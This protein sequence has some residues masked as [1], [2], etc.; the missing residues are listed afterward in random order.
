MKLSFLF[1][2]LLVSLGL[3]VSA[4][5]ARLTG[6]VLDENKQ[7][8]IA[9]AVRILSDSTTIIKGTLVDFDGNYR[10]EVKPGVYT[11]VASLTGYKES[12]FHKIRLQ[13]GD[14]T[15]EFTM[16]ENTTTL[17]EV[18]MIASDRT[19]SRPTTGRNKDHKTAKKVVKEKSD[20]GKSRK[21]VADDAD[22]V[23]IKGSRSEGT[24]YYID[25][26][27]V[28]TTAPKPSAISEP[29]KP[30][31]PGAP[32][33]TS[34]D[35][36]GE[37]AAEMLTKISGVEVA[38]EHAEDLPEGGPK[39]P[40]APRAGLLTAGEWND[41]HNW[42]THWIDLLADG[43]ITQYQ[44]RYQF[45]PVHRYTIML[46]N[47]NDFPIVDVPVKLLG[48][49]LTVWEAR[50]DN[51]GKAELWSGMFQKGAAG[52]QL[53]LVAVINGKET[54]LGE[55]KPAKEGI[56]RYRMPAPCYTP[57]NVDIMWAVDATGSMGDEIEYLKTELL[58]VIQRA[59]L[60][61]PELALRMGTVFYRDNG[62]E[63]L[64]RVSNF[65]PDINQTIQF[66]RKQYAGGGGDY[67]EAVH[68]AL[69]EAI[70]KQQW[71]NNAVARICFLLLDAS[72]HMGDDINA[73]LARSIREAARLGV[74][75]VPIASSGIQKDTEF[76][77][78]FFGLATNGSYVFLT[79]HSGVGS[80][81]LEPTSDEYK[82]EPLN[83]LLV[84]LIT[85]YTT[86]ESCEGQASIRFEV[87]DE[88]QNGAQAPQALYYPNPASVQFTL[89]LPLNVESVTLYDATG[90]A[91]HKLENL[92]VGQ[93]T[94]PVN[95]L[96]EGFYTIRILRE[97]TQQTGKLLVVR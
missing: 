49:G 55:P 56:L 40:P 9:A 46:S 12:V 5:S 53:R 32:T 96:V 81:H 91:V 90:K 64:T 68:S 65:S 71:S 76:L 80:K 1:T 8:L 18:V 6:K 11:I 41:L 88:Q 48:K 29:G 35:V 7:P 33:T 30:L 37:L 66:I 58:D 42:N 70:L 36:A 62:D 86:L 93:H 43:E 3:Q 45:Y 63:Y 82:V 95:D 47:D 25:G 4:Q 69:E 17:T 97:N 84:R 67:P 26:E 19:N 94:I 78:K 50:T 14:N 60:R 22:E 61:N 23:I 74:R 79:D 2:L 13:P 31:A 92:A 83:Q 38:R 44:E 59:K 72:P 24:H 16:E 85:E 27:R 20:A 10:L 15:L 52:E 57:H 73:S 28:T 51:T 87:P 77:M 89:E 39:V 34:P 21:K 54:D 75:I